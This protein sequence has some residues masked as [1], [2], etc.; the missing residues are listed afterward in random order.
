MASHRFCGQPL[1][2]AGSARF[3]ASSTRLRETLAEGDCCTTG[4]PL[5]FARFTV[6]ASSGMN[7]EILMP[8]DSSACAAESW[9]GSPNQCATTVFLSQHSRHVDGE[10]ARAAASAGSQQGYDSARCS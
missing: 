6:F 1:N 4:I 7:C 2:L 5:L 9:F 8:S 10:R 3:V